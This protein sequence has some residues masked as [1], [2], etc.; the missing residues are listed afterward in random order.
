[1]AGDRIA[2]AELVQ[3][4]KYELVETFEKPEQRTSRAGG[5]GSTGITTPSVLI[6]NTPVHIEDKKEMDTTVKRGRGRP[7]KTPK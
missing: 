4:V 3:Q 5:L 6:M 7:R 1:M 2:Q